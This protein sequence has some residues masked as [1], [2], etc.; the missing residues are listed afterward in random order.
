MSALA[1]IEAWLGQQGV[2]L[3]AFKPGNPAATGL[4]ALV[5]GQLTTITLFDHHQLLSFDEA[6]LEKSAMD[7]LAKA[8]DWPATWWKPEWFPF[9]TDL[10]GQLLVTDHD[11]RVIAFEHDDDQRKV[12]ADSIDAYFES[13]AT[14][15]EA[16]A[17]VLDDRRLSLY[18]PAVLARWAVQKRERA[19][20]QRK[21]TVKLVGL[22]A[23][24]ALLAVTA[25]MWELRH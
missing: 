17:L 9:A 14:K 12:L 1:R 22:A 8:E 15:L 23:F 7:R 2:P 18:D 16:G 13:I 6:R 4:H 20:E 10:G 3:P 11:G 21:N 25:V 24:F 19:V 5:D